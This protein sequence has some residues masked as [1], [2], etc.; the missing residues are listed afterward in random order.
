[1]GSKKKEKNTGFFEEVKGLFSDLGFETDFVQ[2]SGAVA[3]QI[4]QYASE[5]GT[6]FVCFVYKR[7]SPLKRALLGDVVT[8]V[9]RL[10]N[11]PVFV[12]KRPFSFQKTRGIQTVMYATG[13][14][15]TDIKILGYLKH[16]N[17]KADE[18]LLFHAG[19][20]APDPAAEAKRVEMAYARLTELEQQCRGTFARI[21]KKEAVAVSITR[22]IV[23]Q[24]RSSSVDFIIAGKS[25]RANALEKMIGST[26]ES[27]SHKSSCPVLIVPSIYEGFPGT[28][29][30]QR[31]EDEVCHG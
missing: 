9:I 7:K 8:D 17:L 14:S 28:A 26:A 16:K 18:L 5:S 2:R 20:R 24:S 27:L 13:L 6:D 4:V 15:D 1:M 10:S 19:E 25:D 30:S 11:L 21:D 22:A 31:R 23:S 29:L 12:Y 3:D